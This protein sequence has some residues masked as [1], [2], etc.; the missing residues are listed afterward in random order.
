MSRKIAQFRL[1]EPDGAKHLGYTTYNGGPHLCVDVPDGHFTISCK[2]S[3][4]KVVTFAFCPYQDDCPPQCV[5]VKHHTSGVK[6]KNGDTMLAAQEVICF[7]TGRERFRSSIKDEKPH[8]LTVILL[9]TK[10]ERDDGRQG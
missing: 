1:L 4:G 8:T 5:D 9:A 2:T 6:V 10:Q 7:A 3:E